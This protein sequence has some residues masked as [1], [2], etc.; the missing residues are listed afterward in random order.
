MNHAQ[1]ERH[2]K[3][4][5]S[6]GTNTATT[7][8]LESP[9][10]TEARTLSMSTKTQTHGPTS[11]GAGCSEIATIARSSIPMIKLLRL[12]KAR[13]DA[14]T[15]ETHSTRRRGVGVVHSEKSAR[16]FGEFVA[17]SVYKIH[18]ADF[19]LDLN[20]IGVDERMATS[21]HLNMR[22]SKSVRSAL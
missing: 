13:Q 6:L 4:P 11:C 19:G 20:R 1:I 5:Q 14:E 17:S 3:A 16:I 22:S 2:C 18:W 8:V 12:N 21:Q 7:P 15:S 10:A 9:L